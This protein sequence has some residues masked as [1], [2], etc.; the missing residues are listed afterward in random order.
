M[1]AMHRTR[2]LVAALLILLAA[3][4]PPAPAQPVGPP[5]PNQGES[6]APIASNA[7]TRRLTLN[8]RLDLVM[9]ILKGEFDRMDEVRFTEGFVSTTPR[10]QA[11]AHLREKARPSEG[12][13]VLHTK[14]F[15]D[16]TIGAWARSKT[17]RT[18]FITIRLS[19][20][21]T[22]PH[23]IDRLDIEPVPAPGSDNTN[24]WR[25]LDESLE[26]KPFRTALAVIEIKPDGSHTTIH[27]VSP[28]E[29]L[30]IGTMGT[31]FT[32]LAL[33]ELIA[34]GG[35]SWDKPLSIDESLRSLPDSRTSHLAGGV[36][37]SLSQYSRRAMTEGD[38]TCADHLF[39]HLGRERIEWA[40]DRV[41]AAAAKEADIEAPTGSE[42]FLSTMENYRLKCGV[43]PLITRYADAPNDER[44]RLLETEVP[45]AEVDLT[46]LKLWKRPQELLR[47]GWTAS[48]RELCEAGARLLELSKKPGNEWS[49][50][51]LRPPEKRFAPGGASFTASRTAGEPGALAGLWINQRAD[52][53]AFIMA[54]VFN[55]EGRPVQ[56]DQSAEIVAKALEVFMQT[57]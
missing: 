2:H 12:F 54:I 56:E 28:D 38:N 52:G 22:Q 40:R 50:D 44:R 33:A 8:R 57:P 9:A 18:S 4:A 35:A 45:K 19:I 11:V 48:P 36:E 14:F 43:T 30:G 42:P 3:L 34:E 53:R 31:L 46:L 37:L 32:H 17:D 1:I 7:G 21:P 26:G 25:A 55:S 15:D 29:R 5:D 27:S 10:E 16:V 24:A 51:A 6:I 20:E 49:I 13:E 39:A 23:R 41:R 47:V